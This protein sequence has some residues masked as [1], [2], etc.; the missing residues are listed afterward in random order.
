MG[1]G[2]LH[3]AQVPVIVQLNNTAERLT[4]IL[5]S[6]LLALSLRLQWRSGVAGLRAA[7]SAAG[8][9][10]FEAFLAAAKAAQEAESQRLR[11]EAA[12]RAAELAAAAAARRAARQQPGPL[13]QLELICA[14]GNKAA[15]ACTR[16]CCG[17]CCKR[18]GGCFRHRL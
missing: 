15:A 4:H 6:L 3:V 18:E 10:T 8:Y 5:S 14:C 13:A 9:T 7:I 2:S 11:E 17:I 12:R 1:P 16:R